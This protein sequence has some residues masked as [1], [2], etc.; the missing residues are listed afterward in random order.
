MNL[1]QNL[2]VFLVLYVHLVVIDG[3]Y[4]KFEQPRDPLK[5]PWHECPPECGPP[6]C[7][8]NVGKDSWKRKQENEKLCSSFK[9]CWWWEKEKEDLKV[10]YERVIPKVKH[11]TTRTNQ[12]RRRT[13]QILHVCVNLPVQDWNKLTHQP[14]F[15]FQP[16][17]SK[18]MILIY[19]SQRKI[20]TKDKKQRGHMLA[21]QQWWN[22]F[23][24]QDRT[25]RG[26]VRP[27]HRQ[28][29]PD[30]E[31]YPESEEFK[32]SRKGRRFDQYA[33]YHYDEFEALEG[34]YD[35]WYG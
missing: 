4:Y 21:G 28:E 5:D 3:C 10:Y 25:W 14:F 27:Y 9:Y 11:N 34:A 32:F 19:T 35:G 8:N 17:V 12:N 16:Y 7:T 6:P 31:L 23:W 20:Y 1:A 33:Y 18:I 22:R 30:D 15:P 13:G 29:A 24:W 26:H 2:S